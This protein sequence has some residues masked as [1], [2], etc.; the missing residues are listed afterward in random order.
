MDHPNSDSRE[1][2]SLGA[3]VGYIRLALVKPAGDDDWDNLKRITIL[4][5]SAPRIDDVA[6]AITEEIE[7]EH[8][9]HQ[10]G[11]GEERDPPFA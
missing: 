4:S 6:Q 3:Q 9:K 11:A 7:A 8:R 2:G 1:F 5:R 10:C